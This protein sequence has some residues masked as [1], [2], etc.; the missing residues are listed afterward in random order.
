ML[1]DVERFRIHISVAERTETPREG[2]APGGIGAELQIR[3]AQ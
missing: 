1:Q 2:Q 3:L